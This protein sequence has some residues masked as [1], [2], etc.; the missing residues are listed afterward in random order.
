[1]EYKNDNG[2]RTSAGFFAPELDDDPSHSMLLPLSL[3][4]ARGES[5]AGVDFDVHHKDEDGATCPT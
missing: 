3:G 1:M 5:T 2:A 4:A